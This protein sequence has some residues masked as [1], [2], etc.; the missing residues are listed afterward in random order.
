MTTATTVN[1]T[2]AGN[3]IQETIGDV[4]R[5]IVTQ[6]PL[7]SSKPAEPKVSHVYYETTSHQFR[8]GE[9]VPTTRRA[10]S[11]EIVQ[12]EKAYKESGTQPA[13]TKGLQ[14]AIT[15]ALQAQRQIERTSRLLQ[16]LG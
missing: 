12:F 16:S 6:L 9:L 11:A 15:G 2:K 5:R 10:T 14:D 1:T 4:T 8:K 13:V 3:T 7:D